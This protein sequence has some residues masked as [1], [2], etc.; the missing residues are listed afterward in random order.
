MGSFTGDGV[1]VSVACVVVR[2]AGRRG[3]E[4][5]AGDIQH[6]LA[7]CCIMISEK[8]GWGGRIRT[9]GARYQKPV[10]YHLATPQLCGGIYLERLGGARPEMSFLAKKLPLGTKNFRER[11]RA[12]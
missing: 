7:V 12:Q 6:V 1:G 11:M 4:S 10:P 9:Y 5:N 3:R 8:S 2:E